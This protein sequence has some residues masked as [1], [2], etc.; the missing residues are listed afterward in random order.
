MRL[1]LVLLVALTLRAQKQ[2]ELCA[3][4]HSETVQDYLTHPHFQKALQCGACHGDSV[5]HRTSQGHTPP[6]RV[7]PPHQIPALCGGCHPGKGPIP[8]L[9][10]YSE[11][12]H[13]RL[14]LEQSKTRA[15]HCGTCHGVHNVRTARATENQCKRCHTSL[16][17]ACS[18]TPPRRTVV[19][20][21]ACHDPHALV[22]KR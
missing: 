14:V 4:C 1:S 21:A 6:D 3:V 9:K 18:A 19:S 7:A 16:P 5:A 13:G 8:I 22:A 2:H 10:Q 15:P 17:S 12:K 11:S 20:C